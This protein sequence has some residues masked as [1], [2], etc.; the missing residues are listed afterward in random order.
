MQNTELLGYGIDS[1][2]RAAGGRQHKALRRPWEGESKPDIER[3]EVSRNEGALLQV[4]VCMCTC[5]YARV[6]V[7]VS[8]YTRVAGRGQSVRVSSL[9]P[10]CGIW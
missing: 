6:C 10:L 5:L 8:Q 7:C 9:L 3:F 2:T 1:V 4:C